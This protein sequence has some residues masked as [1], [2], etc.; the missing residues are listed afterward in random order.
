[1]KIAALSLVAASCLLASAA[2][3]QT[4]RAVRPLDGYACMNLAVPEELLEKR[5][6]LEGRLA[7]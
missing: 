7:A 6:G 4:L 5:K 1:M 3:A 2:H